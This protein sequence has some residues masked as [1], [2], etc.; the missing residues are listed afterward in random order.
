MTDRNWRTLTLL[1]WLSLP[2][3]VGCYVLLW[4][5]LPDEIAVQFNSSGTVTNS[6]SKTY[7]LLLDTAIMLFILGRYTL[8]LW[9][10]KSH[11][12]QAVM[13]SYYIAVLIISA[14]FL[15]ILKFNI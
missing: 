11:R 14:V 10:S 13:A 12:P 15:G 4:D 8:K 3:V 9:G 2:L 1:P 5:R 6:V 7:S